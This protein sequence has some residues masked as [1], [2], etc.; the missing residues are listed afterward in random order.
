ML[1]R[2][3]EIAHQLKTIQV[4]AFIDILMSFF[5]HYNKFQGHVRFFKKIFLT[6]ISRL[7]LYIQPSLLHYKHI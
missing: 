1:T 2:L 7:K 5:V 4:N 6:V 3:F